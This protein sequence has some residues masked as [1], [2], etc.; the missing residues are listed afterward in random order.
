MGAQHTP[1]PW[2]VV[3]TRK[4]HDPNYF[5]HEIVADGRNPHRHS[6]EDAI[7]EVFETRSDGIFDPEGMP[8]AL[9]IVAAPDM[10]AMLYQYADDLR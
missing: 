3:T 6:D 2:T 9:V 4:E 10:L 1:G 8:N 7:A 5:W